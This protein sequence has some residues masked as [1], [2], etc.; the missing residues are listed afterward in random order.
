[1]RCAGVSDDDFVVSAKELVE[2]MQRDRGVGTV[3]VLSS[4]RT[5]SKHT[6]T[7]EKASET[8]KKGPMDTYFKCAALLQQQQGWEHNAAAAS[9]AAA[10]APA[11]AA[12]G[13]EDNGRME[14]VALHG[15]ADGLCHSDQHAL[16]LHLSKKLLSCKRIGRPKALGGKRDLALHV[17][18]TV[19]G[20][21]SPRAGPGQ[22][23]ADKREGLLAC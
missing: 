18:Q 17:P 14:E 15:L 22:G 8:P 21:H 16:A 20:P 19:G 2:R 3:G 13:A 6:A 9:V 11:A 12:T 10:A 1:M 5:S 7:V 4:H 23:R